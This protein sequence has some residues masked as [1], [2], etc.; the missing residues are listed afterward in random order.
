MGARKA[1]AEVI[2]DE[3]E[4]R[5]L[6]EAAQKDP[7]RFGDLYEIHFAQVYSFI[8]RRV[9]NRAI[10]EDLTSD[11]FRKALEHLPRFEWRGAPFASW[12]LRI[13]ANVVA[14]QSSRSSR[15]VALPEDAPEPTVNPDVEAAEDFSRLLRLVEQLPSSQRVVILQRFVEQKSIREIAQHMGKTEGAV[16]QLQLRALQSLRMQMEGAHA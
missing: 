3:T 2:R 10:A 11:A 12:L 15:E 13:A 9:G 8:M 1:G 6:V 16:K 14:D 5:L 7:R 4:E